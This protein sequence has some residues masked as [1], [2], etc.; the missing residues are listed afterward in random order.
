MG[1]FCRNLA[2]TYGKLVVN[3]LVLAVKKK[4]L[5]KIATHF[6][7]ADSLL[8]CNTKVLIE[9][10]F[11]PKNITKKQPIGLEW[12]N[13]PPPKAADRIR[14]DDVQLGKLAFYH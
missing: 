12:G 6:R 14:T 10:A 5:F 1:D 13:R 7:L 9:T 2:E 11:I 8:N 4:A 3:W